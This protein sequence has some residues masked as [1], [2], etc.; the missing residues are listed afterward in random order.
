MF[1][2][3]IWA[4]DGSEH[5]DRALDYAREL[6]Q[7]NSAKL[8]AVHVKEMSVG[9]AAGYPVQIDE[10]EVEQ[11]IEGQARDLKDAGVNASYEQLGTTAGGA[12]HALADAAEEAGGELIVVGTR[13]QGPI[14]GLLLG[15][16]TQRLLHVAPCPVLAV[17]PSRPRNENV[18]S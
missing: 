17:P 14:S 6:A 7:A 11:K 9:R 12:A 18:Q 16:V 1:K 10:E 2:V 15:S 5:A 3:I 8:I 4:S 13:G